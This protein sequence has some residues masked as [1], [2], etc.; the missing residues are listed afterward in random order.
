VEIGVVVNVP[1][2]K[3][4]WFIP[5]LSRL[6]RGKKEGGTEY[7][8]K[9]QLGREMVDLVLT[10]VDPRRNVRL[11]LDSGYMVKPML[12]DLPFVLRQRTNL[13][14]P[15]DIPVCNLFQI[16]PEQSKCEPMPLV[17][18][19]RLSQLRIRAFGTARLEQ[20][21]ELLGVEEHLILDGEKILPRLRER[22]QRQAAT[23]RRVGHG[24]VT[25]SRRRLGAGRERALL[26]IRSSSSAV[27]PILS[28]TGAAPHHIVAI[29]W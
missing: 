20:R 9:S 19:R 7:R 12:R 4:A 10:W 1:W 26:A 21:G 29:P 25:E 16:R 15:P 2:S 18:S 22:P 24:T 5:V 13:P 14:S 23:V 8:T 17:L 3:H 27:A 6:Y 11:L 28:A